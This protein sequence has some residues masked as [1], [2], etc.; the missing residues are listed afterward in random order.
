MLTAIGALLI[1]GAVGILTALFGVGGGFLITPLLNIVLG[2]P[3][4][5]A[6]GTSV[7]QILGVS[8]GSLF[9]RRHEPKPGIKMSIV[10]FGGNFIGV[11]IGAALLARL[12]RIGYIVVR[13]SRYALVD[14]VVLALFIPLLLG[15]A[16][17]LYIDTRRNPE[18]PVVRVGWF[19]RLKIPP[20]ACFESLERPRLSLPVLAYFGMLMGLLT[21]MLGI[22]GGVLLLPALVYLV[23]LRTRRAT[24]TSLVMVLLTSAVAVVTHTIAGNVNYPLAVPLL[25]GGTLGAAFGTS[26]GERMQG[27]ALRKYFIYVL[28]LAVVVVSFRLLMVLF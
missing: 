5:V 21:G 8:A 23:G 22:G 14:L 27:P 7:V 6:V 26:L 20:Y 17:W 16:Y 19:A 25:L 15:I 18:P 4:P 28:L 9:E 3:M 12:E 13:G 1:G 24:S 10:M 2:V 11:Q